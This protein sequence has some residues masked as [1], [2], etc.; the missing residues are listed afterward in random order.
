MEEGNIPMGEIM[1]KLF[2]RSSLTILTDITDDR[3]IQSLTNIRSW[4]RDKVHSVE[5]FESIKDDSICSK[6]SV[7][8]SILSLCYQE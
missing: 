4:V 2:E 5:S 3:I 8:C 7:D 1:L 6:A